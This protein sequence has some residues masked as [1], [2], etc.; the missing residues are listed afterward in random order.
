MTAR[1]VTKPK[2]SNANPNEIFDPVSN[3]FEHTANLAVHS[4]SQD[5]AQPDRRH[6]VE[7]RNPCSLT[8]EQDSSQQ[9][10]R[11]RGVPGPIQCHLVF[12]FDLVTRMGKTFSKL[13][14]A[15]EEKQSFGLC[16]QT[17]DIEKPREFRWQEIEHSV[18]HVWISPG[19]NE[20]CGFVQYDGERRGNVNQFAIHFDVVAAAGL[21]AEV[22]AGF[23]VDRDAASRDQFIAVP[24]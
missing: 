20:S 13:A 18:A 8:I 14:V 6:R 3:G 22:S 1:Q 9:F 5:N 16:V 19:G 24:A 23:A 4:L 17:A 12:L 7:S 11:D 15:C 21:D 10:R 2:T